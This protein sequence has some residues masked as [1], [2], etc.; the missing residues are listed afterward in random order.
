MAKPEAARH[1]SAVFDVE[2]LVCYGC[3][4]SAAGEPWP[5][6]PSGERPCQFCIRNR[7][8]HL[9]EPESHRWYDGTEPI[10]VPMDA[11]QTLEMRQQNAVWHD[12]A[13]NDGVR[14]LQDA[15]EAERLLRGED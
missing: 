9:S 3:A 6:Q 13:K 8:W 2:K 10:A 1:H 15:I 14:H 5:S 11:Y 12:T 4:H 7:T